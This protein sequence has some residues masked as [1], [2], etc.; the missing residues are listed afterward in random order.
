MDQVEK[1]AKTDEEWYYRSMAG[2]HM[3]R[4]FTEL[5]WQSADEAI[6]H[7]KLAYKLGRRHADPVIKARACT[8]WV[9]ALID[10]FDNNA[11]STPLKDVIKEANDRIAEA[12]ECAHQTDHSRI[13]GRAYVWQGMVLLRPPFLNNEGAQR[14]LENAKILTNS[15]DY[16]LDEYSTLRTEI[17]SGGHHSTRSGW[18]LPAGLFLGLEALDGDARKPRE[19]LTGAI[20]LHH[21]KNGRTITWMNKNLRMGGETIRKIL[22]KYYP[23]ETV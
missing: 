21:Y 22:R 11:A 14:S 16:L 13:R 7:V 23:G 19:L 3:H 1:L 2:V 8:L 12:L 9:M 5:E 15:A 6:P 18:L 20:V 4:G 10:K 17:N